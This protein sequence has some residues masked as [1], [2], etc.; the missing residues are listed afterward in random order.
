MVESSVGSQA[1]DS[2]GHQA[3]TEGQGTSQALGAGPGVKQ[4]PCTAKQLA[5]PKGGQRVVRRQS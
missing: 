1:K 3:A 4:G 5:A 2:S